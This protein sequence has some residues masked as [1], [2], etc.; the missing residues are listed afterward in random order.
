[1][2]GLTGIVFG[3]KKRTKKELDALR[4]LFTSLFVFSEQ[5][6]VHASGLATI[7]EDGKSNL[8]K[9]PISPSKMICT[10]G[11]KRVLDSVSNSTTLLIGHSRWKTV[12]SEYNNGNNQPV[13]AGSV[14]GTHNGT[15]RNADSL[16][17]L[18]GLKRRAEVDSEVLFRLADKS[19][20][21]G[22]IN[23]PQYKSYLERCLG[24]M[25]C[26]LVSKKDPSNVFLVKGD[27]P[28]EVYYSSKYDVLI[29]S[30]VQSYIE[31]SIF[32]DVSW[33][34]LDIKPFTIYQTNYYD[35]HTVLTDTF[36]LGTATAITMKKVA[37]DF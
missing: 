14:V 15:I 31:D 36:C 3:K 27:N 13:V 26:V 32:D 17:R 30:S 8:Y 5:R 1:M 4:E 22:V 6:G 35:L 2:C 33:K 25:T 23:L 34:R 29:Y 20:Q 21:D 18:Y 12:G 24:T 19:I 10:L 16:F 11:Y 7:S 9:L 28:L 37:N